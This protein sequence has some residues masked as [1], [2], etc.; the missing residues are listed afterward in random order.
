MEKVFTVGAEYIADVD[1][2]G[3]YGSVPKEKEYGNNEYQG[4]VVLKKLS[5]VNTTVISERQVRF[6]G[7]YTEKIYQYTKQEVDTRTEGSLLFQTLIGPIGSLQTLP[8]HVISPA[9]R[10]WLPQS[11]ATGADEGRTV[12][13]L[14]ASGGNC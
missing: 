11:A 6:P 8:D 7:E 3:L 14:T 13:D 5:D 10:I 4:P 12:D 1:I 9:S 2:T